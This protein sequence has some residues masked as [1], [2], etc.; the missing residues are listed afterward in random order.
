MKNYKKFLAAL[1]LGLLVSIAALGCSN[2]VK[3]AGQDIQESG[4]AV[5][6]AGDDAQKQE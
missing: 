4:K 3:G 6:Q 2:T 1:T 5:E